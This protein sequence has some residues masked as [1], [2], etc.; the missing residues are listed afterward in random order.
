M[1]LAIIGSRNLDCE[2]N[3]DFTPTQII[4]GGAKGIDQSAK[5]YAIENNID[6]LEIRPDYD[7]YPFKVAPIIRNKAIVE[8]SD[9]VIAYWD[10]IS[11]G[12]KYVIDL[13]KKMNKEIKVILI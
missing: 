8:N 6:Y 11:K 5:K 2:I 7:K 12:T 13:C 10:G 9:L 3:L 4:S 1:K